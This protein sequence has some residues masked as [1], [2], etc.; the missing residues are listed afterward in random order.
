MDDFK[1]RLLKF[2]NEKNEYND[3]LVLIDEFLETKII[4]FN[5]KCDDRIFYSYTSPP[6]I[7]INVLG[8]YYD[9]KDLEVKLPHYDEKLRVYC[10]EKHKITDIPK[11][12][13]IKNQKVAIHKSKVDTIDNPFKPK[14]KTIERQPEIQV[15]ERKSEIKP[16][17][18]ESE[19]TLIKPKNIISNDVRI[20]LED[21]I[22]NNCFEL[23][24]TANGIKYYCITN[25]FEFMVE[26]TLEYKNGTN[27]IHYKPEINLDG[28]FY[29]YH[30]YHDQK[31]IAAV[32]E[33]DKAYKG[34][35]VDLKDYTGV[36]S[37]IENLNEAFYPILKK[38]INHPVLGE[39]KVC[40]EIKFGRQ[41]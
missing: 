18:Q 11:T 24:I 39:Y 17:K 8:K 15:I 6:K 4:Q 19:L 3:N 40:I 36:Y 23:F 7:T 13:D 29:S 9:A 26:N 2:E 22:Y 35:S 25:A 16:I 37:F 27:R 34:Q 30:V 32:F 28:L 12:I 20:T 38:P 33:F 10:F 5:L 21:I 41:F 31:I 14:P 1:N